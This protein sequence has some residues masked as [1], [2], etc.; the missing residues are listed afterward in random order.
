MSTS[1]SGDIFDVRNLYPTLTLVTTDEVRDD[2]RRWKPERNISFSR[3]TSIQFVV[4][5]KRFINRFTREQ[6]LFRYID[7]VLTVDNDLAK[8]IAFIGFAEFDTRVLVLPVV[9]KDQQTNQ[10]YEGVAICV[11]DL[12]NHVVLTYDEFVSFIMY[13]DK[14]D[15]DRMALSLLNAAISSNGA[16]NMAN[17]SIV[18]QPSDTDTTGPIVVKKTTIPEL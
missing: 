10:A 8:T 3:F 5:A 13:I 14:F 15:F 2:K 18:S 11:R 7:G 4:K 9:G 1:Q 12:S 17:N 6:Q 16:T